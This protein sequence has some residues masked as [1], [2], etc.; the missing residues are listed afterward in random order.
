VQAPSGE[1]AQR[2]AAPHGHPSAPGDHSSA[3]IITDI[4]GYQIIYLDRSVTA[5][6]S[7]HQREHPYL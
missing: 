4:R 3:T 7:V 1:G 2:L 5:R 6:C